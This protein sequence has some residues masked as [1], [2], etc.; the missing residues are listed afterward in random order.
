VLESLL[1]PQIKIYIPI[2]TSNAYLVPHYEFIKE[3]GYSY[4]RKS[5]VVDHVQPL[6][7]GGADSPSNMQWQTRADAKAKDK[8]ELGQTHK[9]KHSKNTNENGSHQIVPVLDFLTG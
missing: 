7:R 5:Y 8:W 9:M 3:T 6:A 1:N 4:G 2:V